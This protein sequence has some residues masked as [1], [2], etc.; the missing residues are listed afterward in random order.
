MAKTQIATILKHEAEIRASYATFRRNNKRARQG[1]YQEVND[2]LYK[3]YSM[4]RGSLVPVNGP[5]LQKETT[6]IAKRLT[7]T[8]MCWFQGIK[9][10][11]LRNGKTLIV[12]LNV[13]LNLVKFRCKQSK[14][15]RRDILKFV[16]AIGSLPSNCLS[17]KGRRCKGEKH[18]KLRVTVSFIVNA[19]G[20][21][22]TEPIVI[23]KSKTPSCFKYF[24]DKGCK[25]ALFQWWKILDEFWHHDR[26]FEH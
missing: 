3:W 2:V 11:G 14:R 7:N 20:G 6:E 10:D 23:W 18:S 17:E 26:N 21:K 16:K 8:W 4:A 5:M 9:R 12:F 13:L 15:G 24:K 19:A 1:R 22:V 25:C